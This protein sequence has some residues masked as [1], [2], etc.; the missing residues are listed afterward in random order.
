MKNGS[1]KESRLQ[2]PKNGSQL[3]EVAPESPHPHVV[4][5]FSIIG[6]FLCLDMHVGGFFFQHMFRVIRKYLQFMT[7]IYVNL[8]NFIFVYFLF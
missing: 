7:N 6:G 2:L 5:F 8:D 4:P 3:P 1:K